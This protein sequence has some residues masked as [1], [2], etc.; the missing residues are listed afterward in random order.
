MR[1]ILLALLVLAVSLGV[2]S[3]AT[4]E[5]SKAK[6]CAALPRTGDL[7]S[8]LNDFSSTDP[9]VLEQRFATGVANYQKLEKDAPPDIR[10]DV[11]TVTDAVQTILDVVR[12]HP[13][14]LSAIRT[15]LA[16]DATQFASAGKAANNVV[17]YAKKNCGLDLGPSPTSLID[18]AQVTTT[19]TG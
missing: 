11:A 14:D 8:I 1:R 19:T 16:G 15:Q 2:A 6:F 18:P 3:C 13:D 9:S 7:M 4:G 5:G 10:G 12:Q 17:D